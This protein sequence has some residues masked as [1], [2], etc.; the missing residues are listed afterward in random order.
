MSESLKTKLNQGKA[1]VGTIVGLPATEITELLSAVGYEW[2]FIDM[3]HGALDI[4]MVQHLLQA[5][6]P[7][8]PCLV[9]VPQNGEVWI[10]KCLDL[11][12]AGVIVPLIRSLEDARQ[13]VNFSKYPPL[14]GRSV[15]IARAHGFG[16][17]FE[18]YVNRANDEVAL[19]LQIEHIAAV[20]QIE[21]IVKIAGI[22]ALFIGPYDLSASMGKMGQIDD[23][24]VKD[25]ISRV[26]NCCRQARMPLGIF[27]GTAAAATT[28]M[29]AGFQLITVGTDTL[30]MI[31]AATE[32]LSACRK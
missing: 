28:Y 14:G 31:Q 13:A 7:D 25:A 10:K 12:P 30:F 20:D 2:L 1:L 15:G 32:T 11:G 3:E 23:P 29:A 24:E 21:E 19:V 16:T 8:T 5:A 22:D 9:R 26:A 18:D 4:S 6:G 17:R 27:C